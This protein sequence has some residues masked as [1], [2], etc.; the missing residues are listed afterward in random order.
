MCISSSTL[1]C[2][3]HGKACCPKACAR[4]T[5]PPFHRHHQGLLPLLH[6]LPCI[7]DGHGS[8]AQF[9]APPGLPPPRRLAAIDPGR[10]GTSPGE[11]VVFGCGRVHDAWDL[12]R[13]DGPLQEA[14]QGQAKGGWT[15]PLCY[16]PSWPLAIPSLPACPP[17]APPPRRSVTDWGQAHWAVR[18]RGSECPPGWRSGRLLCASTWSRSRRASAPSC[19]S[20]RWAS[21][22]RPQRALVC[23]LF[24]EG[25]GE[26]AAHWQAGREV[27][28][29]FNCYGSCLESEKT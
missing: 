10:R 14:S 3:L 9:S 18:C 17:R 5:P 8:K 1:W 25:K 2:T 27:H 21:T 28:L 11:G 20:I 4:Q 19:S 13:E 12:E 29:G 26:M 24:G 7:P 15:G 16:P 6:W 23:C 22:Q